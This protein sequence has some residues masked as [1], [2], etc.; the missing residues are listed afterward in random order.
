MEQ[1]RARPAATI[2]VIREQNE[3]L[4]ILMLRRSPDASA[5]SSAYVF[6]G[7]SVDHVDA[8]VVARRLV[9]GRDEASAD[10]RLDLERGA[11]TYYCA[12]LRELF[13][14]AGI[15]VAVD[16][17]GERVAPRGAELASWREEL[18]GLKVSWS[19]LLAREGLRLALDE[20]HY[21]AHWVTPVTRP[22]RYDTRFFV[23]RALAGQPARADGIET[24]EHVWVTA[25]AA[26][27]HFETAQ[28]RMLVPTVH[29][30]SALA[31]MRRVEEVLRH[32]ASSTVRRTQPR[33][34]ERDGRVVVVVP[35]EE[36]YDDE[37]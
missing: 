24:T 36:G 37:S 30:L 14:E 34:I 28:W 17:S 7:G 3:A 21:M 16:A 12:A 22:R 20:L 4:E 35:G 15:L 9:S 33:E 5:A 26:L 31:P 6:P 29:T 19:E 32:V 11:L 18:A 13:E 2:I 1:I 27:R 8:E 23:A 10:R 25:D